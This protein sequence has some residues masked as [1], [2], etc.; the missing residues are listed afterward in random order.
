MTRPASRARA[1]ADW[2]RI[3]N[4]EGT[5]LHS[6]CHRVRRPSRRGI[7]TDKLRSEREVTCTVVL[8]AFP[9]HCGEDCRRNNLHT[10]DHN[11]AGM[12]GQLDRFWFKPFKTQYPIHIFHEDYNETQQEAVQKTVQKHS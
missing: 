12:V 3:D 6:A 11:V 5:L 9:T 2:Y 1:L 10:Q 8:L 4:G 7:H